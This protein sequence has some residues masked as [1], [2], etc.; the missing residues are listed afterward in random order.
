MTYDSPE[1]LW[2]VGTA[3]RCF[4][5]VCPFAK[6]HHWKCIDTAINVTCILDA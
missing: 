5:E 4:T 2:H 6:G 1:F 3:F